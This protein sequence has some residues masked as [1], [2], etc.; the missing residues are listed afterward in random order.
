MPRARRD[1]KTGVTVQQ[2]RF[3]VEYAKLGRPS[4]AYRRAY[5]AAAMNEDTIAHRAREL[6]ADSHIAARVEHYRQI[7]ER[8]LE[9]SVERI[10][11]ETARI[12]FFDIRTLY[13]EAGNLIPLHELPEGTARALNGMDVE[14]LY[15]GRGEE[16]ALTGHVRKYKHV[17]KIEALRLL[18]QWKKML[19]DRREVGKPG[20]F[21]NMDERELEQYVRTTAGKLKVVSINTARA[22][23][24]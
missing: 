11:L 16:R 21:D 22:K 15:E 7:A 18:A 23:R 8:A 12:A 6:L 20:E 14:A 10:A 17:P 4:V 3:A 1:P 5:D 19:I 9:V 2:E 24:A 13:D